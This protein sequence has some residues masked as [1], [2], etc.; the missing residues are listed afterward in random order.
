MAFQGGHPIQV[1]FLSEAIASNNHA[2]LSPLAECAILVT[3]C[4]RAMSH[5]QVSKVEQAYGNA[6]VDFW[7]RHEWLD[8]L[9]NGRLEALSASYPVMSAITD[10]MLLFSFMLAQT[11]VIYLANIIEGFET[12]R[13]HH[14]TTINYSRR[15]VLAAQEIARLSKTQENV[16]YFKVSVPHG[17]R[18]LA[19]PF[20]FETCLLIID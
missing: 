9:L 19:P 12:D 16:G 15:A 6:S 17:I 13:S 18:E 20:I 7:L 5:S 4:G 2:L 11:T 1:C 10:S 14:P 8:G 3:I